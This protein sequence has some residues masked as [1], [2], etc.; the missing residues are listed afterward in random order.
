MQ[1]VLYSSGYL[2]PDSMDK[3]NNVCKAC[4]QLNIVPEAQTDTCIK[5][6]DYDRL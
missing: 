1:D 6:S 3:I 5:N 2:W 4:K